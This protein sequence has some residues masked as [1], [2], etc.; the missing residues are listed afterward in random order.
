MPQFDSGIL[1]TATGILLI[2]VGLSFCYKFFLASV[3]GRVS[4]WAGFLPLTIVSPF[5]IHLPAGKKSLIKR[6]HG[7]WVHIVLG[8][9]FL[10]C[11]VLSLAAGADLAGLPGVDTLNWILNGGDYSKPQAVRFSHVNYALSF[12]ILT[13]AG[14]RL[15]KSIDKFQLPE[16]EKDKLVHH[17][18][19]SYSASVNHAGSN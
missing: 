12:P 19:E 10:C 15:S 5:M 9:A 3:L 4:Y 8:P 13:R 1:T 2:L 7:L 17:D 18:G 16:Q 6:T 14:A 11:A